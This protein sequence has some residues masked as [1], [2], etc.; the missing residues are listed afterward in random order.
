MPLYGCNGSFRNRAVPLNANIG[1]LLDQE[2]WTARTDRIDLGIRAMFNF[3]SKIDD[4]CSVMSGIA[5]DSSIELVSPSCMLK[6]G[7]RDIFE[8]P[9]AG[10]DKDCSKSQM[11]FMNEHLPRY[12]IYPEGEIPPDVLDMPDKSSSKGSQLSLVKLGGLDD[13]VGCVDIREAAY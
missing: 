12:R 5:Q 13:S 8:A 3:I 10:P 2:E 9:P 11:S 6:E 1:L 7:T 4:D